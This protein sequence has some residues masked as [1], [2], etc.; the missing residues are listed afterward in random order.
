MSVPALAAKPVPAIEWPTIGLAA[1][2]HGGWIALVVFHA[3]LPWWAFAGLA[4]VLSAWFGSLQ[5]EI[6]HGHPTRSTGVNALLASPP[7]W[8]WLPWPRYRDSHLAHHRDPRLTDPIDDPESRYR[9][10]EAWALIGPAG[11]ALDHAQSTLIGRIAIGPACGIARFLR[12]EAGALIAG[13]GGARR[14]WLVHA[15]WMAPHCLFV[16]WICEVPVWLY[17]LGF[18]QGGFALTLIRSFAEHRAAAQVAHRTAVVEDSAL[19]GPLFLFNNLHAAHHRWPRVPWYRL[20]ALY[21]AERDRLLADNGGLVYRGYG[22]VA[23]RF[24]LRR[25]DL[26]VHPT[27]RAP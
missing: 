10:P 16:F 11:R 3:S 20:P 9:T 4:A 17:A 12:T 14:A 23:R 21:R 27:G 15:A 6:I 18:V 19:L 7:L 13:D 24:L 22:E 2:I 1:A 8:L 26:P 5:H 25:H